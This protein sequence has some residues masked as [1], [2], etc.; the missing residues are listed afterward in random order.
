MKG[1]TSQL[2]SEIERLPVELAKPFE[3]NDLNTTH[4]INLKF[5]F[6]DSRFSQ[7]KAEVARVNKI[8]QADPTQWE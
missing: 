8:I 2:L 1:F 7:L 3:N 6:S 5:D 4:T